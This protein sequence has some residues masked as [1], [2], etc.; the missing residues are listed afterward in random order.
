MGWKNWPYWLIGGVIAMILLLIYLIY[1]LNT[2]YHCIYTSEYYKVGVHPWLG[3]KTDFQRLLMDPMETL[4][5]ISD[6]LIKIVFGIF[7][8][9]ILGWLL[10]KKKKNK[11]KKK[12]SGK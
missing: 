11:K 1:F 6:F 2:N 9:I 7:L 10:G 8:G 3:C 12:R 4:P 5:L